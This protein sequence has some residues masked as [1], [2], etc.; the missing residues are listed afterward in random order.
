M[1]KLIV[2]DLDDTLLL[3]NRTISQHSRS[4]LA[5]ARELG[6]QVVLA[7]G[8]MYRA[9]K[10]YADD[11]NLDLPLIAYQGALIKTTKTGEVLR[12][13]EL[14]VEQCYPI[15]EF[16]SQ[17]QVHANLYI[18]DELFVAEMND[19]VARYASFSAV[20]VHVVG[21][22]CSYNFSHATKIVAIGEPQHLQCILEPEALALFGDSLTINTSRPH[23]LEFG[24]REAT[25]SNALQ[26]LG[27]RLGISREEILAIG[28]G[29]NDLDMIQY[30]GI[31]VAMGNADERLKAVA[32]YITSSN[33]DEGVAQAI[34]QLVL[35]QR[36]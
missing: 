28:D 25:K 20:P 17:R 19:A 6:I 2:L 23:F 14:T 18:N 24:H 8:R 35:N 21:N 16:L 30:A 11:L 3:P 10:Q 33:T 32:D 12:A 9:A 5:R 31:G 4:A 26:F 1:I 36:S 29:V 22:L 15:L 27:Q 13:L 34:E 7:T